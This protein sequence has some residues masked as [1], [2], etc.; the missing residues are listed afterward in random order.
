MCL[1]TKGCL[2]MVKVEKHVFHGSPK[3]FIVP[4]QLHISVFL[5]V[6]SLS[7]LSLSPMNQR[8]EK[9]QCEGIFW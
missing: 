6:L 1:F 9:T 7:V 4:L 2:L 3:L 8:I 5:A